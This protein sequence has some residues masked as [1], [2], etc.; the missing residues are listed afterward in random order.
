MKTNHKT[1]MQV[2]IWNFL[3]KRKV[4]NVGE[5]GHGRI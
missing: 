3:S 4:G 1:T 2:F 5:D